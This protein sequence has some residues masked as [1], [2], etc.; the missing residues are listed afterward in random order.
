MN[1]QKSYISTIYGDIDISIIERA[2]NI[3]MLISDVD[4]VMSNGLIYVNKEGEEKQGFNV[5]DGY[6]IRCLLS[7][8]IKVAIITGRHSKSIYSYF[9]KIGIEHL[10]MGS[11]KKII[12]YKDLMS[13]VPISEKQIAYIGDDLIDWPVMS[14]VGL[15]ITVADGHPLLLSQA[16]YITKASGGKGAVREICDIILIAQNKFQKCIDNI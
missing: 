5:R 13:K 14:L 12:A 4:G 8:G 16:N 15:N 9:N 10:Y 2:S 1:K 11:L 7:C 3:R 6:G